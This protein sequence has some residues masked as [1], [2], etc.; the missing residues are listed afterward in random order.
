ML[1][2]AWVKAWV[3]DNVSWRGAKK[4]KK[5]FAGKVLMG[6]VYFQRRGGLG[7][8]GGCPWRG[9]GWRGEGVAGDLWARQSGGVG[10]QVM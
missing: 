2:W 6:G 8:E 7:W 3:G 1:M 5:K 4:K 10:K 9:V